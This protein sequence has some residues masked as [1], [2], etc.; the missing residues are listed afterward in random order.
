MTRFGLIGCGAISAA[1]IDSL[2][3]IDDAQLVAVW[4]RTK[5]R[6]EEVAKENGCDVEDSI[7]SL[8]TRDDI[9][10]V[11]VCTPSGNHLEPALA[12]MEAGKHVIVEKPMEVTAERCRQMLES[13][14]RN[15]VKLGVV[16][17]SRFAEANRAVRD[18]ISQGRFGRIVL[19]DAYVKWYRGQDYYDSGAWRGTW[20]MDG[21]G[22]LMN[23]A[24][25]AVDMLLWWMGPAVEVYAYSECLAHENI[26]VEDTAVAVVRFASGA[27]GT[28]EATT[29]VY[30]GYP[31][32]LEVH[33][34]AGGAVIVDDAVSQWTERNSPKRGEQMLAEM[35]PKEVSGA[36]SD[37]MAI[38][39][40]NHRRQLEDFIQA[41]REDRPPLVDGKEGLRSVELIRAI[42]RSAQVGQPVKLE[43]E[44]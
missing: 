19:G 41:I 37:P 44:E 14:E 7:E 28:I 10:A 18:S 9:D 32:R 11:V 39:F 42:Y 20:E 13:A 4:N 1:H 27:M 12:A 3:K 22:A 30:P 2:N 33:G 21:G 17:Q 35:G 24:I 5:K 23:Q 36:A 26:E 29:S 25:H 34:D 15:G 6:A 31:K 38:S 16:F 40:D 43:R 8:V